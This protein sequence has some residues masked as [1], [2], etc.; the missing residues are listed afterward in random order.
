MFEAALSGMLAAAPAPAPARKSWSENH[1]A[2]AP[3]GRLHE[4]L[5]EAV[6]AL[7]AEVV[8]AAEHDPVRRARARGAEPPRREA[9]RRGVPREL[10]DELL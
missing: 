10:G 8:A 1:A 2:G 6:D 3:A 9:R 4:P 7:L 5:R